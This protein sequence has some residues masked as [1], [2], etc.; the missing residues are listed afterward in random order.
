MSAVAAAVEYTV[1]GIRAGSAPILAR[2]AATAARREQGRDYA[3]DDV[4]ALAEQRITLTGIATADGGAG[5]AVRDVADLIIAIARADS[6]VAQALRGS[7]LTANQVATRADL[8]NRATTLRRL[9]NGDLF[10]G[11]GN[12]R[13]GGASGSVHTTIRPDGDGHVINGE[14]YYSTGGLY[15]SWFSG[16]AKDAEGKVYGFTVPVDRPGVQ[17]LDDF[18]AVGQRLTASGT[19]RLVNVRVSADEVVLRDTTRLDNPWLGSFAQLYLA[20]IEAGIAAAALDDAV[21][22]VRE[23]AR[24]IKHSTATNSSDDPYVRQT[25]GE[26]AARAQAARSVVLFAAEALDGLSAV[27]GPAARAA[28]AE[29]AVTVAQSGVV[30]IESALRAA[31]LLFDV[32][33]GSIT[34]RQFG[35]DRHWRNARTV[36]NHN[37][38]QWKA[39]VSGAYHLVGE[40]PPTTGLF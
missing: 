9:R 30:A 18:D 39:A 7:F 32:A 22:F 5:G 2:L 36:A 16:S 29:V 1:A 11:T 26:I 37:P 23:R 34:G 28:G 31:E 40:E 38:R 20:A 12:E 15:A 21:R 6:N 19:T 4:R 25:V 27:R 13:T 33:G 8:P 14:K 3:F 10:A 17:R 35:L 24:P